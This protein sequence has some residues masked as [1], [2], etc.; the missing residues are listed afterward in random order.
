MAR[1]FTCLP[2]GSACSPTPGSPRSRPFR[3]QSIKKKR[4]SVA[5]LS[6]KLFS[7]RVFPQFLLFPDIRASVGY[8]ALLPP[9]SR[10]KAYVF[11]VLALGCAL[12]VLSVA[13]GF[14][15]L[16]RNY[17]PDVPRSG[18]L[19]G[20]KQFMGT[21]MI[22][23]FGT[24]GMLLLGDM[25]PSIAVLDLPLNTLRAAMA[26]ACT[27]SLLAAALFMVYAIEP[28]RTF[29]KPDSPDS[30]VVGTGDPLLASFGAYYF[31]T[32]MYLAVL[33]GSILVGMTSALTP[34]R[35][36]FS[37]YIAGHRVHLTVATM[38]ILW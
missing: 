33:S 15:L 9:S 19:P 27:I 3:R 16:G 31:V 8:F 22:L 10:N 34:A 24:L 37:A 4:Q 2:S 28:D 6:V 7:F 20:V 36:K 12:T 29:N 14:A 26:G 11:F 38:L 5:L 35:K 21:F 25:L 18:T 30:E 1:I 32:F 23:Y 13:S 17:N